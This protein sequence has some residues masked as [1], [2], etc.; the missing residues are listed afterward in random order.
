MFIGRVRNK[1]NSSVY[2]WKENN[3][4]NSSTVKEKVC[5]HNFQNNT[6]KS[7]FNSGYK[8]NKRSENVQPTIK[9]CLFSKENEDPYFSKWNYEV[10]HV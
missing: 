2:E 10:S 5:N 4:E 6:K 3:S 8:E 1:N 9:K 7:L